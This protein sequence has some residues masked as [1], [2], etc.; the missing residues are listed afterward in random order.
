MVLITKETWASHDF[1]KSTSSR[2]IKPWWDGLALFS[3]ETRDQLQRVSIDRTLFHDAVTE[4]PDTLKD[5]FPNLSLLNQVVPTRQPIYYELVQ[6]YLVHAAYN[7]QF[8]GHSNQYFQNP[9]KRYLD[10]MFC[11]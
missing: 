7:Q 11:K 3:Q 1:Y 2:W 5:I 9:W 6:S 4:T 8:P 10:R